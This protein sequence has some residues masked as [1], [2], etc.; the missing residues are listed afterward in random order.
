MPGFRAGA[1]LPQRLGL[2]PSPN[3]TSWPCELSK[4]LGR[5]LALASQALGPETTVL[6]EVYVTQHE[7][8]THSATDHGTKES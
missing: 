1:R 3:P 4:V 2:A 8:S 5:P 7:A 6:L